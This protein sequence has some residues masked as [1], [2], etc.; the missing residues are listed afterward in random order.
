MNSFL[1]KRHDI[2]ENLFILEL[3]NN[4]WG[5]LERG[6]K[7]IRDHATVIRYNNVKAAIKLQFRDVEEFVHKDFKG[8][9]D[10]RY[11]KKTEDT[12]LTKADFARMVAEIRKL[13]A[14]PMATP[15]DE[16][17]VDLCVEFGMPII[18]IASSDIAD[19]PL[20]ERIART[21]LPVI[22]S[23]GG[24]SEKN[25]DDM[26]SF[27][28][29][30]NIP[31]ALNH[32]VSLYPSEDDD[33]ELNQIDYLRQRYPDHVIGFSTHEYHS[34]DASMFI[35]YAKGARTVIMPN[36]VDITMVP[37]YYE[38]PN[39][40]FIRQKVI[41]FNTGLASAVAS[42]IKAKCPLITLYIPDF[43]ALFDSMLATPAT[44]GLSNPSPGCY[45][46][47]DG[48]TSLSSE[49]G[50]SYIFWDDTDPTA[51]A[52]AIMADVAQQMI[53]PATFSRVTAQGASLRLDVVNLPVGLSGSV[54]SRS[55][56]GA[57]AWSPVASFNS[58]NLTQALYVTP[59]G[60]R[61]FYRLRFPFA[62][63]WP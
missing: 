4:H 35:S 28:E 6:L 40:A 41:N 54:E 27:F 10:I 57:G 24:A 20:I 8:N 49:P 56:A 26:V 11:I 36:A 46:I 22:A 59:A 43:F 48:H 55:Q 51:K 15:F 12:K 9:Q 62:W 2:F 34:W 17:S 29:K 30:R 21:K 44:Y 33:L 5:S 39:K 58:T 61:Q 3:A 47:G 7:I 16:R 25:L 37:N 53:S 19:W 52:Q 50:V 32:C 13:A 14:I 1:K 31:L 60:A 42:Q 23:T 63:T 38:R 18:K 45:A